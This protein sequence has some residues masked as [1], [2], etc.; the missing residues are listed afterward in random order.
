MRTGPTITERGAAT[1]RSVD[2]ALR[3]SADETDSVLLHW[4]LGDL[5]SPAADGDRSAH[6]LLEVTAA[7]GSPIPPTG[8]GVEWIG[9]IVRGRVELYRRI[10]GRR[11]VFQVL[12]PGDVLGGTW[13]VFGRPSELAAR[14]LSEVTLIG[15][16]QHDLMELVRTWP[17]SARALVAALTHRLE[18]MQQ[19]VAEL[20][21]L[22]LTARVAGFLLDETSGQAG[23][24]PLAQSTVAQLLG[25]SRSRVNRVLKAFEEQGLVQLTY[26]RVQV[27]DPGGLGRMV[28]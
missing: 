28:A 3:R 22:D 8:T 16:D 1:G 20:A 24:V 4:L 6:P 23:G 7:S 27:M 5:V 17:P 14:A 9:W 13:S 11:V 26:R 19:R 10:H 25:A 18:R 21:P 15:L 2:E 12:G